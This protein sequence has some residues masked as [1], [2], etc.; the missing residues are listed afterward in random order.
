MSDVPNLVKCGD[1]IYWRQYMQ[2]GACHRYPPV[3]HKLGDEFKVVY[4]VTNKEDSC[5]EGRRPAA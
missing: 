4:P 1:C 3:M 2:T 5:G